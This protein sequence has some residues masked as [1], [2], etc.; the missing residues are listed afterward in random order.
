MNSDINP[1]EMKR[2]E[3]I[4]QMNEQRR[5]Q[6]LNSRLKGKGSAATKMNRLRIA[7]ASSV[8]GTILAGTILGA[9]AGKGGAVPG[10]IAG[11]ALGLL[12]HGAGSA[13]GSVTENDSDEYLR[14]TIM[15]RS[16]TGI[17]TSVS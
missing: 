7:Q 4:A 9:T 15:E 12:A 1:L 3:Q 11:T 17:K 5:V 6:Y 16:G 8:L 10:A 2:L 14:G 13:I